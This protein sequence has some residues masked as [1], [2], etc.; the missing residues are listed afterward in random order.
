MVS[1]K[2]K[3]RPLVA[4]AF[5]GKAQEEKKMVPQTQL[6]SFSEPQKKNKKKHPH[7]LPLRL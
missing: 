6:L 2:F 4:S 1:V 5:M 7:A 3:L